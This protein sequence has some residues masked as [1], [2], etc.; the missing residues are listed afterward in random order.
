MKNTIYFFT[1]TGN[2]LATAKKIAAS[3]GD[4]DLVPIA[5]YQKTSGDIVPSSDRVGI[6]CPVYFTG[7]PAMVASFV[8]RLDLTGVPYVFSVLTYGGG[9][10]KSALSQVDGILRKRSGRGLSA[11][12]SV[13]MPGNY[14]LMYEPPTGEKK[15]MLLSTADVKLQRITDDILQCKE[16]P[17]PRSLLWW[18]LHIL[19]YPWF[20]T[21]VHTKDRKFSVSDTCTSCGICASV[22]PAGNIELVEKKPVWKHHC[23]LCCG[24]IHLCPE[25]AIQAGKKTTGWGRYRNP[26]V[27]IQDLQ[28]KR[29]NEQ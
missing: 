16:L 3:L 18:L 15:E 17:L 27:T 22:C 11:G 14:V 1:G 26:E 25:R 24:C 9:G 5:P 20:I 12:Y 10:E 7:L 21:R 29:G 23:E 2:S 6:V 13:L 19:V 8:A 4:C 28:L